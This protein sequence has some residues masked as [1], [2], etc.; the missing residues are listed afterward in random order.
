MAPDGISG[1]PALW[2][3]TSIFPIPGYLLGVERKRTYC[4]GNDFVELGLAVHT[5]TDD[6]SA[7]DQCRVTHPLEEALAHHPPDIIVACG[8]MEML[9]CVIGIAR[10]TRSPLS[11]FH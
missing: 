7:G 4:A 8:P 6:G 11:G 5:T 9:A 2:R 10:K 1:H 3:S